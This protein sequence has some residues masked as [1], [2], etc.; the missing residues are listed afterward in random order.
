MLRFSNHP[1]SRCGNGSEELVCDSLQGTLTSFS[2]STDPQNA[3]HTTPE[4][5]GRSRRSALSLKVFEHTQ[6]CCHSLRI[7]TPTKD[8]HRCFS[9]SNP[10]SKASVLSLF[11]DSG[12]SFDCRALS[13]IVLSLHIVYL[14]TPILE[15][16]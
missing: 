8:S 7:M 2:T 16:G 15:E 5:S 9:I 3:F 12:R 1:L 6:T 14:I 4:N 11:P 13:P 10:I